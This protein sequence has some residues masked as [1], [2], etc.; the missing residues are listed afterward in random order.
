MPADWV[1][2][3]VAS[4]LDSAQVQLDA[5]RADIER[6]WQV[7]AEPCLQAA[8]PG[9]VLPPMGD[10][11]GRFGF[12][13]LTPQ[14]AESF[15]YGRAINDQGLQKG[16]KPGTVDLVDVMLGPRPW[17]TVTVRT[18]DGMVQDV[19]YPTAGCL[20]VPAQNVISENDYR[21]VLQAQQEIT[22]ARGAVRVEVESDKRYGQA[23]TAWAKCLTR[24]GYPVSDI[25]ANE[26]DIY[27]QFGSGKAVTAEEKKRATDDARC[28]VSHLYPVEDEIR[29]EAE[30]RAV[31]KAEGPI[32]AWTEA[33]ARVLA[34]VSGALAARAPSD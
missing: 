30:R 11:T 19:P 10:R 15:G 2:S 26:L 20:G 24:A 23:I 8:D 4:D 27:R 1:V 12:Q 7:L 16:P 18:D 25:K 32:I 28:R 3:G 6:A 33:R 9:Y 14:R 29:S 13:R 17:K 5:D 21:L 22:A 34:K 31:R